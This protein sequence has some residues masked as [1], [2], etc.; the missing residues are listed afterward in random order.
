MKLKSLI[1]L[2]PI[3]GLGSAL[4]AEDVAPGLWAKHCA[5]C[6]A[7]DGSASTPI[8]KKLKVGDYTDPATLAEVSD[9]ELFEMTKSGVKGTKMP[10]FEKKLTDEEI[11]ALVAYMRGMAKS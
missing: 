5:K 2:M 10:G 3:L 4:S 8:G 6:H 11:H 7:K 1:L 9:E